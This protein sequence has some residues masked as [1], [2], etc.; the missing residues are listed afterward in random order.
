[1]NK[2]QINK[3]RMYST[4]DQVLDN[5]TSIFAALPDLVN[6]HQRLKDEVNQINGFRQV[7]EL[8]H[9]GLTQRKKNLHW[10]VLK[11]ITL[12]MNALVAYANVQKD[13]TLRTQSFYPKTTLSRAPDPVLY[14]IGMLLLGLATP[15]K[16]ELAVYFLGDAEFTEMTALME[17]FRSSIP[18][19]RVASSISKVSTDN[20]RDQF[21]KVDTLLKEELD[22]LITLYKFTHPDFYNAYRNARIIVDYTG[23]GKSNGNIAETETTLETVTPA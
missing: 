4:V 15:L 14:D 5:Y 20:I 17:E 8:N 21:K 1:M 23:R 3:I 22:I 18:Q 6:G 13:E 2:K 7:Q 19:R 12:F 11:Q 16:A 10:Q 9:N